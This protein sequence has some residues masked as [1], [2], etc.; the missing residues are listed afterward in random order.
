LRLADTVITLTPAQQARF[1]PGHLGNLAAAHAWD[2]D[3]L[4][5]AGAVRSTAADMLRYLEA[6][7]DPAHVAAQGGTGRTLAAALRR[8]HELQADGGPTMR[9]AYAWLHETDTGTYWHN[10]GTGG[11]TAYAFFNPDQGYAGVVLVN[12]GETPRGSLADTLGQHVRQR[13]TGKP[14]ISLSRW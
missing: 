12:M 7:L 11:Y 10:G 2:L 14:A 13:L 5:G 8:S 3:A 6:Q 9:I 1:I 4:A